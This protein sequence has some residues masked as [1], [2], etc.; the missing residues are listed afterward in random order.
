MHSLY[1]LGL[2]ASRLKYKRITYLDSSKKGFGLCRLKDE[3]KTLILSVGMTQVD[4]INNN[5]EIS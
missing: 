3:T 2:T 5:T 1:G 4:E